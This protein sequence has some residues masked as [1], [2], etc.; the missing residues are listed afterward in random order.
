MHAELSWTRTPCGLEEFKIV[1]T[2]YW[3]IPKGE[4][5]GGVV[6]LVFYTK[7]LWWWQKGHQAWDSI[8]W[9]VEPVFFFFF[10][11]KLGDRDRKDNIFTLLWIWV[12]KRDYES[13]L[14]LW[15]DVADQIWLMRGVGSDV[16]DPSSYQRMDKMD[17]DIKGLSVELSRWRRWT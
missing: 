14:N 10:F 13:I 4:S 8:A 1:K 2:W 16:L 6:W 7:T 17:D 12:R 3:N 9:Q 15:R 11:W 5:D